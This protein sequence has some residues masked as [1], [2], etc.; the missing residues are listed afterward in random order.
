MSYD[1]KDL[2]TDRSKEKPTPQRWNQ[3]INDYEVDAT[4]IDFQNGFATGTVSVGATAVEL[5]AWA[6]A[7]TSRRK[8]MLHIIGNDTVYVGPANTVTTT[9]GFPLLPGKTYEFIFNPMIV[10]SIFAIAAS[11]QT[12]RVL[13]VN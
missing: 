12:V 8:I 7:L 4:G 1:T 11:A 3:I 10:V 9:D 2:K 13:E 6:S 5:M